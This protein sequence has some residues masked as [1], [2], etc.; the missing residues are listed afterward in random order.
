MEGKEPSWWG[1]WRLMESSASASS[2]MCTVSTSFIPQVLE[3]N[4]ID[5]WHNK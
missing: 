1:G 5:E 3:H 4:L 2:D